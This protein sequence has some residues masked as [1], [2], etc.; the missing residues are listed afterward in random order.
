MTCFRSSGHHARQPLGAVCL[1][2]LLT[3]PLAPAQAPA[4]LTFD[5]RSSP[6]ATPAN[7][8]SPPSTPLPPSPTAQADPTEVI[9]AGCA[10]CGNLPSPAGRLFSGCNC[11]GGGKCVPGREACSPCCHEGVVGRFLCELYQCFCCPDPCYDPRWLPV[12]DA[13]FFTDAAR[14]VTQM[15]LRYDAGV[16]LILPD[17]A[18]FFWARADGSGKG[19]KPP[20]PA[21]AEN[22]LNYND[23]SLYTEAA[24]GRVGVFVETPYRSIDPDVVPHAAG[25][26]DM[27]LGIKTLMLDCELLQVSF[28]MRTYIPVGNF[29]KGTGNGH[30]SLEPSLIFG[31]RVC[32]DTFLQAQ[33]GEWIPLGGDPSYSGAILR[34]NFSLNQVLCRILPDVPLL[35]TLEL[36]GYSFQHGAYTDPVFGSFQKAGDDG[37]LYVGAGLRLVVC[38]KIDIGFATS[39]AVTDQ[40]F[41][42]Q[43]YRTEFRWRF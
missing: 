36:N 25:F 23:I 16:N 22:R 19:P 34:Y 43:I 15:R 17:R 33:V 39:F 37:Y 41:A 29:F 24:T 42:D 3:A 8:P 6:R 40:H 13:A 21:I 27:N 14:P 1:V 11:G 2:L 12:A 9:Q 30:M 5:D 35:G 4:R 10:S 20:P 26:G 7:L 38:D 31:L 32:E 18:E 28:Q